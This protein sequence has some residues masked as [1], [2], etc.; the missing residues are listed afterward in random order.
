M[1]RTA[2]VILFFLVVLTSHAQ[3]SPVWQTLPDAPETSRYNDVYFVSPTVGWVVSGTAAIYRTQD[4]G[5]SWRLQFSRSTSHFR[6][7]AFIDSLNGWV[8]NVGVGE[9]GTTDA[10]VLYRT[11]N[12][13]NTWIPVTQ[14]DGPAPR[15]LCGMYVVNDS[16]VVGVGRV[17]GPSFFIKTTDGGQTW[18]SKDMS[19]HAAGLIDVHFFDS[20]TGIAAGL[21]NSNHEQ[22]SG[23]ILYTEDG[24]ETW[25]E[26]FRTTRTGEWI[27]KLS[28]PSSEVGYASLQRNSRSPIYFLKTTDGGATWE[29]KLFSSDYYF[30]QGI[31]FV[32]ENEGWIGGN[33][34]E[35]SYHTADGGETW[36]PDPIGPRMNRFRFLNDSLGYAVGRQVHKY[37]LASAVGIAEEGEVPSD[38]QLDS[39]Y[40]N[41]F[42]TST[43]VR[44]TLPESSPVVVTVYDVLGRHVAEL[45]NEMQAIGVHDVVWDG[46]DQLGNTVG[47]GVYFVQVH[48]GERTESHTMVLMR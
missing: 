3:P 38:L 16:T 42:Q 28:F 35:D 34:S 20:D 6:S 29:E 2:V 7:V 21:T 45:V 43:T 37:A 32:T 48:A 46:L 15:G 24:G 19:A 33:S 27:W 9:F 11:T 44:Y 8:G 12:A 36:M 25:E 23:V 13:G 14:F 31:G 40:P 4:G 39:N 47:T 5:A 30:V 10:S 41:P 18:T 22:S 1:K 26:R 17:R